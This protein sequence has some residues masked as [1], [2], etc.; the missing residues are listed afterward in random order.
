MTLT[1]FL[2]LLTACEAFPAQNQAPAAT[3][4][5]LILVTVPPDA[6]FTPTPFQPLLDAEASTPTSIPTTP[7]EQPTSPADTPSPVVI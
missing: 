6:T 2:L 3:P 4:T 5:A 7:S 1:L